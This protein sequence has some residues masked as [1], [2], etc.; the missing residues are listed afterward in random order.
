[1]Q[2][3]WLDTTDAGVSEIMLAVMAWVAKEERRKISERTKAGLA[4]VRAQG[5]KIGRPRK[6]KENESKKD[7]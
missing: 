1:M 5:K 4:R 7:R 3:S 6:V 2:E